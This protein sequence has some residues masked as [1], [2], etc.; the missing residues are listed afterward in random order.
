M[1]SIFSYTLPILSKFIT[2]DWTIKKDV[3]YGPKAEQTADLYLLNKQGLHPTVIFVHGGGWAGG[4]KSA[5]EGRAKKYALAGFNVIAINYTLA[6][7][8]P[9]T[10]WPAQ[11][12][13]IQL[14]M[15]WIK[16]NAIDFGINPARLCV[17]GDSA[18]GHLALFLGLDP[19]VQV[20]LNMFGPCDLTQPKMA[21]VMAGLDVFGKKS[22]TDNPQLYMDASPIFKLTSGYP[23]TFIAH[24][25]DD[26][27]VPYAEAEVLV[28]RLTQL[29][30]YNK[31]LTY[32]GGHDLN[33]V[34]SYL[35]LWIELKGLWF[36]LDN[37]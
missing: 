37:I 17:G 20:V 21:E 10:Q 26:A 9:K 28:K 13:D 27:I 25:T 30:V 8:D 5:Y 16:D 4:D 24:S 11:L 31:L 19:L 35:S 6:T 2:P 29:S 32:K 18:G 34:P 33:K 12:D 7:P 3:S 23:P 36:T 22:Y 1:A 15:N 14:A